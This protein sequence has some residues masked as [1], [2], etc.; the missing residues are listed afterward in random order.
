MKTDV[1]IAVIVSGLL[2]SIPA[3]AQPGGAQEHSWTGLLLFLGF[4]AVIVLA[5]LWNRFRTRGPLDGH[6]L[7]GVAKPSRRLR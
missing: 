6:P 2:A 7:E 4:T 5:V 1:R 3:A